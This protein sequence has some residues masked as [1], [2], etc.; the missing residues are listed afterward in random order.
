METTQRL[1]SHH[2]LVKLQISNTNIIGKLWS[3]WKGKETL[4]E[5]SSEYS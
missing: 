2:S 1:L 4:K 3:T 5:T